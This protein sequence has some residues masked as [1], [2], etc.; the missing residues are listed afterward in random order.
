MIT[1]QQTYEKIKLFKM[2]VSSSSSI[3]TKKKHP[4]I[5]ICNN[6]WNS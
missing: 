3:L 2:N 4:Q 1:A 5:F 6:H